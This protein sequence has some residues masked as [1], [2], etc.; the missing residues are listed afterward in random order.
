[1]PY[2]DVD[3]VAKIVPATIG[4][5]IEQA[6]EGCP[7]LQEAYDKEP[8]VQELI[9]TAQKFEGLVRGAACTPPASSSRP[10]PS[11]NWSRS[12][13][14]ERRNRHRLRHEG[15]REDGPAQDG[16]LGLTTLTVIDDALKLIERKR[17]NKL[18]CRYPARRRRDLQKSLPRRAHLRVFQFESSGMRDVLRRYKP[19]R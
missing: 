17:G 11:P 9:D 18:D 16:L 19:V 14:Q 7:R 6:L 2:G 13:Q 12:P 5:T 3:R 15:G 1:M 8:Q 4:I 10:S